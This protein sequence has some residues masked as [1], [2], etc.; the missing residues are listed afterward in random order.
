MVSRFKVRSQ[1]RIFPCYPVHQ[2]TITPT[3]VL[4]YQLG[5][6]H[7]RKIEFFQSWITA[8]FSTHADF[9]LPPSILTR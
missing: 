6:E 7:T 4:S 8:Q 1:Q 3:T 2:L 9:S 5:R